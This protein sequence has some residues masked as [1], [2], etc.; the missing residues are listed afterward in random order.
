M[1]TKYT[2]TLIKL[3]LTYLNDHDCKISQKRLSFV[4][5]YSIPGL[6]NRQNLQ[7]GLLKLAKCLYYLLFEQLTSD[8]LVIK[9]FT[10]FRQVI[11]VA[12]SVCSRVFKDL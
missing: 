10:V 1:K 12:D 6:F 3:L 11:I 5:L 9:R 4:C 2:D 7:R 8:L